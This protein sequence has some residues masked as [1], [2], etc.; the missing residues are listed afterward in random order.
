M[1][2]RDLYKLA[3]W[4]SPAYPVGAFTYSHGLEWAIEAGEVTDRAG[5]EAW[6]GDALAL[7]AGRSDG[8]LLAAAW[9]AGRAGDEAALA[10]AAELGSALA[11]SRER[12]L[13]TEQQGRAFARTTAAVWPAEA[14]ADRPLPYPVAVGWAA[15][16]HGLALRPSLVC[17]L[18]AFVANLASAAVRAVPLGQ[19]DGQRVLAELMPLVLEVAAEAETAP[20]E[21]IGGATLRIDLASLRHET[22]YS[23]LFRS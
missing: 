8:I 5:L 20:L 10:E 3:A 11:P 21:E 23:R 6:L 15:G 1:D 18:Q 19:T 7:G 17:Y 9:R 16:R 12:K 2:E 4:L 22:Q 14:L 13:E